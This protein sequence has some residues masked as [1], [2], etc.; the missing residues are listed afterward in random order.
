MN[1][2][3]PG[4][5]TVFKTRYKTTAFYILSKGLPGSVA[6]IPNSTVAPMEENARLI[7]AAPD[8]L[9]ALQKM[10][11][12]VEGEYGEIAKSLAWDMAQNAINKALG[13]TQ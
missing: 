7:S 6:H 5:W 4:P 11:Q 3:T 12:A 1:Q 10:C 9:Y 13:E 8:L 2:H